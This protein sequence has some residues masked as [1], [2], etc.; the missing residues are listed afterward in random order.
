LQRWAENMLAYA[1][2]NPEV[3]GTSRIPFSDEYRNRNQVIA[4]VLPAF[5]AEKFSALLS[6]GE[7]FQ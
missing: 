5:M 6:L 3:T 2:D 4:Q 1:N 7:H